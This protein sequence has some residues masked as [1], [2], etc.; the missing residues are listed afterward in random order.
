[1][2]KWAEKQVNNLVLFYFIFL[3]KKLTFFFFEAVNQ[4]KIQY[5]WVNG[6]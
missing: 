5:R 3:K 1:M 4:E 2:D 6:K